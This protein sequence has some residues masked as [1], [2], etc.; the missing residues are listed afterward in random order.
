MLVAFELGYRI[1]P[2]DRV[3]LNAATFY[4]DYNNLRTGET[5]L[6]VTEL[7]PLPPHMVVPTVLQNK[8]QGVAYG[9]ELAANWRA[10]SWWLVR[11][12]YTF[13]DLELQ[14]D[15]DSLDMI[16]SQAESEAP[17]NL[18]FIHSSM[19]LP[20]AVEVD[21]VVRYVDSV[22]AFDVDSY[23]ELDARVAWRAREQFEIFIAGR[24]LLETHHQEYFPKYIGNQPTDV[25]RSV[26][27]GVTWRF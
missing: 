19:D 7:S 25:E 10:T 26:S 8:M 4:H 27:A 2:I 5:G 17:Q 23:L 3:V 11:S 14:L 20:G 13:Y 12:G 1:Q 6:P 15:A 18:A 24:N 21:I 22:P 16:E 9:F